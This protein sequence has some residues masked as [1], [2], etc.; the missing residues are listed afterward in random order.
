MTK[1][2]PMVLRWQD[3]NLQPLGN[4]PNELPLLYTRCNTLAKVAKSV[5]RHKKSVEV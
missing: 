5:R 3:S 2:N 4:E 1:T